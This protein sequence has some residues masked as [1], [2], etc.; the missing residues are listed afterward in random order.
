MSM[1][2]VLAEEQQEPIYNW[3]L[4][5]KQTQLFGRHEDMESLRLQAW[6]AE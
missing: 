6:S 2:T 4:S 5:R 3:R 1:D